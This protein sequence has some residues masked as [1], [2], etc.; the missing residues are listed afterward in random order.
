MPK[1]LRLSGKRLLT[2]KTG[3]YNPVHRQE[4]LSSMKKHPSTLL[5]LLSSLPSKAPH[6]LRGDAAEEKARQFLIGKGLV[7]VSRNFRCKQGELDL[8]MRDGK[9]LVIVEVRFRKSG[10]YGGAAESITRAKQSRIIAATQ[11]Y[12]TQQKLD[13]PVRFDV[14]AITG[15]G[16]IDWIPHAFSM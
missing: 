8:I 1:S 9:I 2:V 15:N 10:R 4:S 14:V 3:N 5:N 7:P 13:C 6:L 11:V 12:L 16:G